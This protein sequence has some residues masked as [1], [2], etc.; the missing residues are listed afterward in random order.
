MAVT[1]S[2]CGSSCPQPRSQVIRVAMHTWCY[3]PCITTVVFILRP[4]CISMALEKLTGV[5]AA[6]A[7]HLGCWTLSELAN[8]ASVSAVDTQAPSPA[9][10]LWWTCL[11]TTLG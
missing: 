4:Q 5:P 11:Q 3:A 2:H 10:A 8:C 7:I 6:M 1:L 9:T